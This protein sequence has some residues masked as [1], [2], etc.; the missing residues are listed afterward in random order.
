MNPKCDHKDPRKR[1]ARRSNE[2]VGDGMTEG[3]DRWD[4]RKKLC[5]K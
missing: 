2:E 5:A 1:E 4:S 3:R